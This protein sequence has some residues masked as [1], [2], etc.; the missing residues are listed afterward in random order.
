[1][2]IEEIR[3]LKEMGFSN[4]EILQLS[5]G[6]DSG[7]TKPAETQP[8]TPDETKPTTPAETQPTTPAETQ[9]TIPADNAAMAELKKTVSDMQNEMKT[10]ITA[11]QKNNLQT[12]TFN[13]LP[14]EE[15]DNNTVS[16][17]SEIIRPNFDEGG[18][19]K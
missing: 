3:E 13:M 10:F 18:T 14:D 16:A 7:Q 19:K 4:Q 9:P 5:T 15:L 12:A 1:M 17:L 8:T 6:A 2:K 11:M